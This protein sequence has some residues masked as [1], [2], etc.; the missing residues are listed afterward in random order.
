M[1]VDDEVMNALR[2]EFAALKDLAERAVAQLDDEAFFATL[3][4]DANSVAILMKHIG[5]NL[6]SR[7]TDP[8]TTDGEKPDRNRDAEFEQGPEESREAI[9]RRWREGWSVL[10]DTL[11]HASAADLTRPVRI[12]GQELSFARAL[13]RSLAHT[14]GH[15]H[16]I[17]ML[18]KHWRGSAWQTLSLPRR[19]S[20]P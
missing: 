1:A 13:T 18:A 12:R 7:W 11:E 15:V 17:V 16:Q 6:R 4:A 20:R 19:A 8:F 3:D 9:E 5:G 2:Q 14:A 10:F